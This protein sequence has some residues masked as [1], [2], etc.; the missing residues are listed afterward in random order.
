MV[1]YLKNW[2]GIGGRGG[3][4]VERRGWGFGEAKRVGEGREVVRIYEVPHRSL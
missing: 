4:G 2:Y 1:V 3:W